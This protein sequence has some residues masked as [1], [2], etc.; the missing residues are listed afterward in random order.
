[1]QLYDPKLKF[2]RDLI[3]HWL[4][5]RGGA[6]VPL[7]DDIDPRAL[8]PCINYVGIVD[9]M[10]PA[11]LTIELAGAHL[12][13]RYGGA[14]RRLNWL[15]LVPLTLGGAAERAR[16]HIRNLPCGYYHEFT[17]ARDHAPSITAQTL[18]LPL[19]Y[20]I[21]ARPH[22]AIVVTQDDGGSA[23]T[24]PSGWVTPAAQVEHFYSE[25]VDIGAGIH[26]L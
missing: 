24:R 13:R 9:L 12:I 19:R 1:M 14:I 15:D 3:G 20:R 23:G 8:Q 17:V 5:I 2:A 26:T 11:Q 16:E 6:L 25:L 21:G 22:V 10:E 18:A 7:D 4:G